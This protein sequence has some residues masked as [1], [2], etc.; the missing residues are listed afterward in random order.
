[1]SITDLDKAM[2]FNTFK[3]RVLADY[4]LAALSRI[5]SLLGR[6][7]V[8]SGKAKFG[9]F[10]DGKELPQIV[11]SH[12]F[13]K[14]DWRSGYY[15][16]QTLMMG[17]DL[18]SL[19]NFFAGLYADTNPENEPF[20]AGRQMGGHFSTKN[21]QD[22]TWINQLTQYNTSTDISCTAGQMPRLVGLAYASKLFRNN[23][24]LQ[25]GFENFSHKGDEIAW[26][27]IGNASTSEGH[28][29]EAINAA[30]V[31]QI[32]MVIS[33]W[34]DDYGISVHNKDHT[35]KESISKIL[36][37]FKPEGNLKGVEIIRVN[38]WDYTAL[39]QTY[40]K[41][42]KLARLQH[43]PVMVHV[44]ELTQPLGHSTSGSHE[45]YKDEKRLAWEKKYDCNE[46]F[47]NW[48]LNFERQTEDGQTLKIADEKTLLEI[49][50]ISKKEAVQ[51]RKKAVKKYRKPIDDLQKTTVQI[52]EKTAQK[53]SHKHFIN[54]LKDCLKKTEKPYKKDIYST[55]RNAL[56]Y[57]KNDP[58]KN[59][60][61]LQKWAEKIKRNN[62][63]NLQ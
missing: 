59:K 41:A 37:G 40:Q 25:K 52:L 16:D 38:G 23:K 47:R 36:E 45:R 1:M 33:I 2:S 42:E 49:E 12:F 17:L 9:I 56:A 51:A 32:P 29:F 54:H 30:G 14:G 34:D 27:T 20:S 3:K 53:S 8:L 6:R 58:L 46:Q 4:R 57:L 35:T 5:C 48:I 7:E 19:E 39:F 21:I 11:L 55:V 28:F 26:G 18:M 44:T 22:N 62:N 63:K 43:I 60:I 50:Q 24:N 10:G 31:L 15:R 13:K 61:P